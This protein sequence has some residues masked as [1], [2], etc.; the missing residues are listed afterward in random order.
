MSIK[1]TEKIMSLVT[2]VSQTPGGFSS[3]ELSVGMINVYLL[4]F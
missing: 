3:L 2:H 1:Q 4:A